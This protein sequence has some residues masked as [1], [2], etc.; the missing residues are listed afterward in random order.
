MDKNALDYSYTAHIAELEYELSMAKHA[1]ATKHTKLV[2]AKAQLETEKQSNPRWQEW[3]L[4]DQRQRVE[5]EAQLEAV[6]GVLQEYDDPFF[7][8]KIVS[9]SPTT[10]GIYKDAHGEYVHLKTFADKLKAAIGEGES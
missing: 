5:L 1:T 9:T 3:S 4:R 7:K 8:C 10:K 6:R 2:K